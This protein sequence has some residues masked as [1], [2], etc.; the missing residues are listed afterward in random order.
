M[1]PPSH[2]RSVAM[3]CTPVINHMEQILLE[4][5]IGARLTQKC[6][7]DVYAAGIFCAALSENTYTASHP[8]R[9]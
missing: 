1:G 6:S 4:K 2:M 3:R 7:F 9:P 8:R 5:L